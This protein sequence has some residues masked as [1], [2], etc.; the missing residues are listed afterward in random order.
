MLMCCGECEQLINVDNPVNIMK[1]KNG[2]NPLH[3]FTD[4]SEKIRFITF[5]V[6]QNIAGLVVAYIWND[7]IVSAAGQIFLLLD[8]G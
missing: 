3:T 4:N 7:A 1:P 2:T 6:L 5:T 8:A